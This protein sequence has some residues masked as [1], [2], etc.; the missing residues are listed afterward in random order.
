MSVKIISCD[1][2]GPRQYYRSFVNAV[3][4]YENVRMTDCFWFLNTEEDCEYIFKNLE[5]Y[6]D[7]DDRLL[8]Q[9]LKGEEIIGSNL[10]SDEEQLKTL[11]K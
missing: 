9:D 3:E 8:I 11:F 1:L 2:K 6:L 10:L 5:I 4:A 7:K